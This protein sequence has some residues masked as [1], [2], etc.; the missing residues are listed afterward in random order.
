MLFYIRYSYRFCRILTFRKVWNALL[1]SLQYG[2]SI[3][4]KKPELFAKPVSLSVEPIN[5][6]NLRCP[7]CVTGSG[8]LLR[9]KGKISKDDFEKI[10][11][12]VY[13]ELCYLSLYFQG[14]PFL[15][16]QFADFVC[17]AKSKGIFVMSS[18]N[19]HFLSKVNANAIARSKLDLLIISLDGITP[20]SYR[21]YR[22]GGDFNQVISGIQTLVETK[23]ELKINYPLIE[24]QFIVFKHNE[25]EITLFKELGKKLGVDKISIKSAQ[26]YGP[27]PSS[28]ILPPE[29]SAYSRYGQDRAGEF[30]LLKRKRKYC[31]RQWSSAVVTWEGDMAPCCFD[32]DAEHAY[33]NIKKYDLY[34]LW[35]NRQ[36]EQFRKKLFKHEDLP[37]ICKN[38]PA[39]S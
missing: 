15:H 31:W 22:R 7:E 5:I 1:L 17:Y 30:Y 8:K 38:C 10:I 21:K 33:G 13:K 3:L 32:K 18:T 36:A 20:E 34:G 12:H 29:N 16:P 37:D 24:L 25:K 14:E 9:K 2:I 4:R 35:K 39:I 23:K 6:C 11:D 26:I 19:G 28:E 27:Q